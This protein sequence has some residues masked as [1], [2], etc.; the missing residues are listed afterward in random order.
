MSQLTVEY[1]FELLTSLLRLEGLH[2][3]QVEALQE[4]IQRL[5]QHERL[6]AEVLPD[7]RR[8]LSEA[9]GKQPG[10]DLGA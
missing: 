3:R 10:N 5:R 4:A 1:V 8:R 6:V 7:M 9:K 2:D